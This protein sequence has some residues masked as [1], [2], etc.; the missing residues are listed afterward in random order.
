MKPSEKIRNYF[1]ENPGR[2]E[3]ECAEATG[4]S[5][6]TIK[7]C[8]W[9]DVQRNLAIKDKATGGVSYEEDFVDI[10]DKING[11]PLAKVTYDMLNR[12]LDQADFI[13][14][15]ELLLRYSKEARL[16]IAELKGLL[17]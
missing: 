10:P 17:R 16:Y 11:N 9:R 6:N 14:D 5:R 12:L 4:V 1:K 3:A 13:T 7:Q 8:V 15:D 2:T